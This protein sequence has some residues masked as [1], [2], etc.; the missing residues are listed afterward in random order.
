MQWGQIKTLFIF[1]FLVL[2]LFLLQQFLTK[3]EEASLGPV[4]ESMYEESPAED[5][6]SI[7]EDVP[8]EAPEVN[9]LFASPSEFSETQLDRIGDLDGQEARVYG[10]QLLV[11]TFDDPVEI[12]NDE[13]AVT[14]AVSEH[15]PF[16]DQY[17]YWGW[18]DT[19]DKI[20]FFQT[21]NARTVY[22]N[23]A[24]VLMVNVENGEM[25]GY[26]L[27]QLRE[28]DGEN[29]EQR[30]LLDPGDVIDILYESRDISSGDEIT[31]MTVGYHSAASF[32]PTQVFAPI[33]KITVNDEE[34]LFLNAVTGDGQLLDLDEDEFIDDTSEYFEETIAEN[35]QDVF[36]NEE[37]EEDSD[38]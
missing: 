29:N 8:E 22:Y 31:S 17:S 1:S 32:E 19:E 36:T 12:G 15:V 34:D 24:G 33:W 6:V 13:D 28:N 4:N 35:N 7:S 18:N 14:D 27:T 11:S 21:T 25:T 26:E 37:D 30:D 5:N 20:L 38:E 9:F 16:S 3:Q 10:D 23:S 2:D